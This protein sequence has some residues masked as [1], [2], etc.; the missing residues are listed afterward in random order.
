M[1]AID[2]M[3]IHFAAVTSD[4]TTNREVARTQPRIERHK[5]R[6]RLDDNALPATLIEPE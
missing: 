1:Q 4:Q 5:F 2:D 3:E 6:L